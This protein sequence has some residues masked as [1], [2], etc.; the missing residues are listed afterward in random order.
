M[1][2]VDTWPTTQVDAIDMGRAAAQLIDALGRDRCTD[3]Y[4]AL[5]QQGIERIDG[6]IEVDPFDIEGTALD[7]IVG[8]GVDD[9]A[10]LVMVIA[11]K[12]APVMAKRKAAT[13][14]GGGGPDA[15]AA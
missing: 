13:E 8:M 11:K 12:L 15:S 1:A 4:V 9:A 6:M 7:L 3:L 14:G 2:A 10:E 5:T